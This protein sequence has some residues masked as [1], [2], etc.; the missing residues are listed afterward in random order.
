MNSKESAQAEDSIYYDWQID[1]LLSDAP[2]SPGEAIDRVRK[3][4][5]ETGKS[6]AEAALELAEELK[7]ISERHEEV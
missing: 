6:A 1:W 5:R 7:A 2:R 4:E 3:I